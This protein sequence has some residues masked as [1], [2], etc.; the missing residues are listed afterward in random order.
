V[1][2]PDIPY[3]EGYVSFVSGTN[4]CVSYSPHSQALKIYPKTATRRRG[5]QAQASHAD[6]F[7]EFHTF[8]E[9]GEE[10]QLSCVVCVHRD[11]AWAWARVAV[12]L[13]QTME[14]RVVLPQMDTWGVQNIVDKLAPG[15]V[16]NDFV[17]WIH[18]YQGYILVL[19][20]TTFQFSR[21]ELP[22]PLIPPSSMFQLGQTND[23]KLCIVSAL[24]CKLSVWISKA[25]VEGVERFMPPKTFLLH[26]NVKNITKLSE[27]VD[28]VMWPMAVINGFVYLS[29]WDRHADRWG[30]RWYTRRLL[31]FCLDTGEMNLL[32]K[33][34]HN[35]IE[36]IYPY[37]MVSWPSS[38]I[39]GK[40]SLYVVTLL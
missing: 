3:S 37:I 15:R 14:W 40:V 11:R 9:H 24:Q 10:R 8:S 32:Y 16:V 35:F 25:D 19:N 7:L 34:S 2:D 20:T 26:A 36:K 30:F 22:E 28:V 6:T 1:A 18:Q 23:G 38:L 17:C 12:F 21:M 5:V 29:A 27:E 4:R 39:N 13:S 31:S 33:Q